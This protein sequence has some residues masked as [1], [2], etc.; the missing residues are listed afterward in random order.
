ML[1]ETRLK[2]IE[3]LWAKGVLPNATTDIAELLAEVR[4]LQEQLQYEAV[5]H[6]EAVKEIEHLNNVIS[7]LASTLKYRCP[8]TNDVPIPCPNA[9]R[10]I[11]S[12]MCASCWAEYLRD[13]MC[14]S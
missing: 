11:T 2:E 8:R 5:C 4:R 1:S 10:S 13:K 12:D 14:R 7:R 9:A 3:D 6:A